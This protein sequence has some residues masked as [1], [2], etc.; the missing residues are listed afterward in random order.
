ME[1][2]A[3]L[4][5]EDTY[6]T[7]RLRKR[8][9]MNGALHD[10]HREHPHNLA[11]ERNLR[12]LT[13]RLIADEDPYIKED[14]TFLFPGLPLSALILIRKFCPISQLLCHLLH[15]NAINNTSFFSTAWDCDHLHGSSS[16]CDDD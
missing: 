14:L 11:L 2:E 16:W 10:L 9:G 8:N 3:A 15:I 12:V 13:R 1:E 7:F 5:M 4:D 6:M